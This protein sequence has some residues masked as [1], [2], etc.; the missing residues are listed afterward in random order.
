MPDTELPPAETPPTSQ[1]PARVAS[2]STSDPLSAMA[3]RFN[4]PF[5]WFARRFVSHFGLDAECVQRLRALEERGSVIYVMRY[6]SRLDYFLWNTLFERE[7]L[8][9]SSFANGIRF[10]YYRPLF[11]ALRSA[12]KSGR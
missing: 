6:S 11:E 5:R 7:G 8:R 3:P 12:S 9:L 4:L 1:A 10:W 2:A